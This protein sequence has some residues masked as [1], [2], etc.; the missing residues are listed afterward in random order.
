MSSGRW[1]TKL[2]RLSKI[3]MKAFVDK[4]VSLLSVRK[5]LDMLIQDV[6]TDA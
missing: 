3:G 6:L 2:N 5:L 4:C 1:L